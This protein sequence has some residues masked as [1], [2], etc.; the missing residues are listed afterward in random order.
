M[1]EN[2]IRPMEDW[3][4]KT[5]SKSVEQILVHT[6]AVRFI[7]RWAPKG[8]VNSAHTLVVKAKREPAYRLRFS[9]L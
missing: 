5:A 9:L 3:V 1:A 7:V 6:S 8:H 2:I 4:L